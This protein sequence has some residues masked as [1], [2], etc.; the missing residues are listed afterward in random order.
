MNEQH[1]T[2]KMT[3]TKAKVRT[4]LSLIVPGFDEIAEHRP[5]V[6]P[7]VVGWAVA[8]ASMLAFRSHLLAALPAN[9]NGIGGQVIE[10]LFWTY[11]IF[12][13]VFMLLKSS[14]LALVGW[15]LL[16][17]AGIEAKVRSIISVLLY[18]E[19]LL[20]TNGLLHAIFLGL[21]GSS[22]VSTS[23]QPVFLGI[24]AFLDRTSVLQMSVAT[25]FTL[26]HLVWFAFLVVALRRV[27]RLGRLGAVTLA[28]LFWLAPASI[29]AI[30]SLLIVL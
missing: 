21:T 19:I 10:A 9:E 1:K 13:P 17:L 22:V 25:H 16:S 15:A 14:L 24:S 12:A 3:G 28:A 29:T 30:R 18:G 4:F 8:A 7:I 5:I 6:T 26:L 23:G 11:V 27:L 20:A 2:R